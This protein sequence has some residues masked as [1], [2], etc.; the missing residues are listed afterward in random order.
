VLFCDGHVQWYPQKDMTSTYGDYF[1]FE[2]EVHRLWNNDHRVHG[3]ISY[4]SVDGG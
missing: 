1:D 2:S 4:D 3:G